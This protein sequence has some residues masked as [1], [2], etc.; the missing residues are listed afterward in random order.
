MCSGGSPK[1]AVSIVGITGDHRNIDHPVIISDILDLFV[2]AIHDHKLHH[3][4]SQDEASH[5][6][7]C[8]PQN[9][10]LYTDSMSSDSEQ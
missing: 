10:P 9:S 2:A 6:K 3:K 1:L 7:T 8:Y 5:I 4:Y